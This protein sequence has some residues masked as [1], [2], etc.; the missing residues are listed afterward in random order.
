MM[1]SFLH[2]LLHPR[3]F[4]R[5]YPILKN[6]RH[7]CANGNVVEIDDMSGLQDV[8]ISSVGTNNHIRIMEGAKIKGLNVFFHG[9]NG[10]LIIEEDVYIIAFANAP[11]ILLIRDN[12]TINIKKGCLLSDSIRMYT[13]DYHKVYDK[14][15]LQLQN[16]DGDIVLGENCWIGR[17]VTINKG[18]QIAPNNVIGNCS[19]VTKCYAEENILIAGNPAQIKKRNIVWTY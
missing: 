5:L 1:P 2:L 18:V 15:T 17:N 4:K 3:R 13:T 8:R 12:T 14:D 11:V 7:F 10:R 16:P 6:I 19:V 9:D